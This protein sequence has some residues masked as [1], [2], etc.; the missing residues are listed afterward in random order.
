MGNIFPLKYDIFLQAGLNKKYYGIN[1][2]STYFVG[3]DEVNEM[4]TDF[5]KFNFRTEIDP[6]NPQHEQYAASL[7]DSLTHE[8][9]VRASS[10]PADQHFITKMNLVEAANNFQVIFLFVT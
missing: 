6:E 8:L 2:F 10:L 5:I 4:Q 3:I 7:L 9:Q 1:H